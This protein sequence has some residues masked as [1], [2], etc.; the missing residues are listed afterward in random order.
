MS[1]PSA[2]SVNRLNWPRLAT[3]AM[4]VW[5]VC[6][7]RIQDPSV[8]VHLTSSSQYGEST[9]FTLRVPGDSMA[10]SRGLADVGIALSTGTKSSILDRIS[11]DSRLC[12]VRLKGTVRT[13]RNGETCR[14]LFV[15]STY[16]PT[17]CSSDAV[18]DEFYRKLSSLFLKATFRRGGCCK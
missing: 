1:A 13:K 7:T 12:A 5:C 16:A 15:T 4:D 8:F 11:V 10:S 6:E 14:R 9:K 18:K 3:R 17:D 2:K